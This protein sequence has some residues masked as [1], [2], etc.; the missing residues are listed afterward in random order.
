[1]PQC[2]ELLLQYF[3]VNDHTQRMNDTASDDVNFAALE[4][5]RVSDIL[6]LV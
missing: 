1:M 5:A 4:D 3:Q 6:F 2:V